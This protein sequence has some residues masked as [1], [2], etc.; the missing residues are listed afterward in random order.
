M[1]LFHGELLATNVDSDLRQV[2]DRDL[3]REDVATLLLV[4]LGSWNLVVDGLAEFIGGEPES[5]ASVSHSLVARH[6]KFDAVNGG[7]DRVKL[8]ETLGVV[9][10]SPVDLFSRSLNSGLVDT[11]EGEE[12]LAFVGILSVLDG[13]E[14]ASEEGFVVGDIIL[15]DHVL[16]RSLEWL[17]LDVVDVAPSE[18]N[19]A[20]ASTAEELSRDVAGQLDSLL[21]NTDVSNLDGVGTNS[22]RRVGLVAVGD[23]PSIVWERVEGGRCFGV[24]SSVA[25]FLALCDSAVVKIGGPDPKIGGTGVEVLEML[26]D[27]PQKELEDSRASIPA[28][29]Y[30]C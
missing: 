29:V 3:R 30:R 16:N 7:S 26:A 6:G 13:A 11:A 15:E 12:G 9:D 4:D 14:V 19:Q 27:G 20:T 2:L 23:L 17:R 1:L 10:G 28:Q 21:L 8:P 24:E 18:A 25:E 5:S 22:S